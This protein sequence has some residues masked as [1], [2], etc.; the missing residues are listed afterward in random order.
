MDRAARPTRPLALRVGLAAALTA[1]A[2]AAL[3]AAASAASIAIGPSA[4]ANG[5]NLKFT[6]AKMP[7]PI[8]FTADVTGCT[9]PRVTTVV[10]GPRTQPGV[11]QV[12]LTETTGSITQNWTLPK[13]RETHRWTVALLCDEGTFGAAETR[14][15]NLLPPSAHARLEGRFILNMLVGKRGK[16][17]FTN[18]TALVFAPRCKRGV[19]KARDSFRDIWKYARKTR[20]YRM[21]TRFRASCQLGG[22]SIAGGSTET[23]T[24]IT[25]VRKT[26]IKK[27]QRF[28][29]KMAGTWTYVQ[30]PTAKGRAAGCGLA[31]SSGRAIL[32]RRGGVIVS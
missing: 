6:A 13:T 17:R 30:K 32:T 25:K 29:K 31:R 8:D 2:A 19:C 22:R 18:P 1:L 20:K 14:S 12:A 3:P 15:I 27:G 11:A 26:D 9:N 24:F 4:P 10:D 7:T 5:S 21:R 16:R 23:F 28:V